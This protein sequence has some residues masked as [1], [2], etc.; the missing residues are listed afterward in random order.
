MEDELKQVKNDY[1]SL[2]IRYN[3]LHH[4]YSENTIIQSMAEMRD[5]YEDLIKTTV[6][7]FKYQYLQSKAK[8]SEK[9][10]ACGIVIIEHVIK[11]ITMLERTNDVKL[12]KIQLELILLK[13]IFE[14]L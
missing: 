9:S 6:P 8:K 4:E 11:Q 10:V 1:E 7:I 3:N 12:Q 2:L 5:R 13:D 14:D